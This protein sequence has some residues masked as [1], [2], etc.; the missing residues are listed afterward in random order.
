MSKE[1]LLQ[2]PEASMD[3]AGVIKHFGYPCEKHQVTTRDGYILTLFRIP[4]GKTNVTRKST[5]VFMQHGLLDSSMTWVINYPSQSLGFILADKGYDVWLGNSRGNA[6]SKGHTS[7]RTD[8]SKYW[9]FSFNEMAKYDLPASIDYVIQMTRAPQ[10][11]YIGHSQGTMIAFAQLSQDA[12]LNKKIKT[13]VA[14]APIASIKYLKG[15]LKIISPFSA[16]ITFIIKALGI[17]EFLPQSALTKW[18]ANQLCVGKVN[19]KLCAGFLFLAAGFNCKSMNKTRVPMYMEHTPSGT[20]VKN[21]VHYT[22]LIRSGGFR[23][24]DFGWVHNLIKYKNIFPPTY[25]LRKITTNVALF[26]STNDWLSTYKDVYGYLKPR[27]QNIIH[28]EIVPDWNHLDFVWAKDGYDIVY[29]SIA[30]VLEIN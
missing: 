11:N 7:Y 30:N 8:S 24:Y 18:F 21:L 20:S 28:Q 25:D 5:P 3:T 16:P 19:E 4:Y 23:Q 9:S 17:K 2:N 1:F 12:A 6:Y 14:L 26:T 27:L 10:V 15:A 29:K 22:Q 13:F